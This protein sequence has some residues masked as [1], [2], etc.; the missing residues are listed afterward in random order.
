MIKFEKHI[1]LFVFIIAAILM[2]SCADDEIKPEIDLTLEEEN[3][4][5]QE[6][7]D[8]KVIFTEEGKLQG[9]LYSDHMREYKEPKEK[10]LN[11]VKIIFY[12]K[13]G[14]PTSQLTAKK[15]KIDELTQDMY[16]I[17]SVVAINDS[18]HVKLE[19]DELMWRKKDEKIVTDKFVRITSD[20]EIIEGYGF[21]S[22]Q[23]I[24]NYVI[25]NVTYQTVTK[26]KNAK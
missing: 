25:R 22:D 12:N 21:E 18:S 3:M 5:V 10:L 15:G 24:R 23:Q 9:I 26:K 16:A 19:T 17:D 2:M 1:A 7:W 8:S 11:G 6:S 20:E 13:E 4:P 14:K